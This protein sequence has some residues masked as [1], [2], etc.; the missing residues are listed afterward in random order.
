LLAG[1][2]AVVGIAML[3]YCGKYINIRL[4][5]AIIERSMGTGTVTDPARGQGLSKGEKEELNEGFFR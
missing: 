1:F 2:Y 3:N 5:N 4:I